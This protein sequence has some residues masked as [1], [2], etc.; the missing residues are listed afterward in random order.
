VLE[1]AGL[2]LGRALASVL[3][4]L[5]PGIVIIGGAMSRAGDLLL[6][7]TR[8]GLRRHALDSVAQDADRHQPAR[9]PGQPGRRRPAGGRAVELKA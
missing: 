6:G 1:D 8:T 9:R 7:P 2:H 3:N 4:L 5:N